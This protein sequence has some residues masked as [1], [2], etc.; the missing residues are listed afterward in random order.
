MINRKKYLGIYLN[1]FC[2]TFYIRQQ[3][4]KIVNSSH[5]NEINSSSLSHQNLIETDA[6][7]VSPLE[8]LSSSS[9]SSSSPLSPQPKFV[10]EY[11]NKFLFSIFI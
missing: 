5:L 8:L 1:L 10:N 6:A 3:Q 2:F 11:V 4:E 9:S 7:D